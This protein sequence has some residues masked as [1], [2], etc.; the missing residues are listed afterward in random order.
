MRR[1]ATA[2]LVLALGW[3]PAAAVAQSLYREGAAG[4]SLFTDHRARRV[5]DIVTILITEQTST[6]RS[7]AT[8]SAQDTS[9][10]SGV[11]QFPTVFDPIARRYVTPLTSKLTGVSQS[12]SEVA[13][14]RFNI[15]MS[16]SASHQ[17]S[18]SIDRA[19]RVT[20]QIAA[21][22]VRV[23]DNGNLVIEGRRAVLVN[24]DTQVITLSGVIR[25]QDVSAL[26]TVLSAQIADAEIQ[27]EGRG[28]TAEAQNPGI[29]YRILDWLRIF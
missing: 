2:A 23:L 21:R 9:R 1:M 26:N 18:A 28:I 5:N 3:L 10:S 16:T 7:A 14:E 27:V 19:D 8:K 29:F 6:A 17:G 13:R 11:S 12:P 4:A 20:G 24:N 25:P 22:V 15:D